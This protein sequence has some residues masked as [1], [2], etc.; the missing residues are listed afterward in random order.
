MGLHSGHD[1]W[2]EDREGK[3]MEVL[4]I[5]DQHLMLSI[6]DTNEHFLDIWRHTNEW[7]I[8]EKSQH[9]VI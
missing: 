5:S 4:D 2:G 9:E 8:K 3:D 6:K 1:A 7:K